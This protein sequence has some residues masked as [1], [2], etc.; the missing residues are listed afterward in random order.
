M[1][2]KTTSKSKRSTPAKPA[3]PRRSNTAVSTRRAAPEAAGKPVVKRAKRTPDRADSK[4]RATSNGAGEDRRSIDPRVVLAIAL[5]IADEE[6]AAARDRELASTL[7][8]W[9]LTART[10]RPPTSWRA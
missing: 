9:S 6:A 1:A 3:P 10:P 4:L 2:K 5:A 8:I 7:S